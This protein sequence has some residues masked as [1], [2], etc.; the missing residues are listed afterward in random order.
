V[1]TEFKS[2]FLRD[3]KSVNDQNSLNKIRDVIETIERAA[4]SQ[5]IVNLKKL[6]GKG[7]VYRIRVG[8]Y[9]L[10][11]INENEVVIFVRCLNRRDIYKHFP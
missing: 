11:I 1:K 7:S 9:R 4:S 10:G 2:S 6:Q 5:E 3:L 8:D